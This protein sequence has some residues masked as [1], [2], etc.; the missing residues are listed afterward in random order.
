MRSLVCAG[1]A[2]LIAA[3][4]LASPAGQTRVTTPQEQL[5]F[6]FGDDYRLANYSQ[7]AE[8]WRKLDAQSD[9]MVLQDIGKTAEG[10]RHLAGQP[11]EPRQV[12][13]HLSPAGICRGRLGG[14]GASAVE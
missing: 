4:L 11:Q 10:D 7:I 13:R 14:R 2:A 9:R 1:T 8:Y 5:G 3:A 12:P 6:S